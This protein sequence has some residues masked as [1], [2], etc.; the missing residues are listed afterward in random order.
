ML[1]NNIRNEVFSKSGY[2]DPNGN[3]TNTLYKVINQCSNFHY[4]KLLTTSIDEHYMYGFD[5][6]EN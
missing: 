3:P 5:A 2:P 6:K 1:Y 4:I